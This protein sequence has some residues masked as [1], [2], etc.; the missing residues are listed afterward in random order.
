MTKK[1]T[2][3]K[4]R[5]LQILK[6]NYKGKVI[7]KSLNYYFN[8]KNYYKKK[9]NRPAKTIVSGSRG[10]NGNT[11]DKPIQN[12][13]DIYK[14]AVKLFSETPKNTPLYKDKPQAQKE[15]KALI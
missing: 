2:L 9:Y 15:Q 10:G 4:K 14:Y 1:K 13:E 5:M 6:G 11:T 7:A 3:T 12:G 8:Q